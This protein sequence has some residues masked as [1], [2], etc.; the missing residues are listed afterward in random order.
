MAA[1]TSRCVELL[2]F[3]RRQLMYGVKWIGTM[4]HRSVQFTLLGL[5]NVLVMEVPLIYNENHGFFLLL[6]WNLSVI[7]DVLRYETRVEVN[8]V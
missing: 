3:S 7:N 2:Q 8:Q 1:I 4:G 5:C 6:I